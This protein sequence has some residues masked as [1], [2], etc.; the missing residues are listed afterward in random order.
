[1]VIS[2]F[3]KVNKSYG[4]K[5]ILHDLN[6][7]I[8]EGKIIG[9]V[10]PNGSG[11]T[12][13]MKLLSK[14][15]YPTSGEILYSKSYSSLIETPAFY[16]EL[17]GFENL[18]YFA[19]IKNV[20]LENVLEIVDKL[21]ISEFIKTK[22]SKYSLGMKQ[23]A[24]LALSLLHSPKVLILDEPTN[25][26][27][28]VGIK[29]LRSI[30]KK[31]AKET[32]TAILV[33]SHILSEMELMCDKVA[34]INN[35]KLVKIE[36]LNSSENDNDQSIKN[37]QCVI[38]VNDEQKAVSILKEKL[39]KDSVINDGKVYI[40]AQKGEISNIIKT[41]VLND[42]DIKYANENEHTLEDL[43]FDVTKEEKKD[44]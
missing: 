40:N 29:D 31:L 39:S 42:I 12:T 10:G 26:L 30:L 22:V 15:I 1:M 32:G 23:R 33:S 5:Q 43:F 4:K 18:K 34:V 6:F 24:G 19:K 37:V 21:G 11:K 17:S 41:L 16:N 7:S 14:L 28:P 20:G 38:R 8:E 36:S 44:E 3:S 27:D 2:S 13:I 35:G 25:G 9:L